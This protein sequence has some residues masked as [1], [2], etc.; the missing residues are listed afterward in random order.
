MIASTHEHL[1]IAMVN[2]SP[3]IKSLTAV[4]SNKFQS[5]FNAVSSPGYMF[6]SE[7]NHRHVFYLLEMFNYLIQY[8][9]MGRVW[10]WIHS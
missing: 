5:L 9:M 10:V 3:Y 1:L 6:Y 8:Q 4:T 7:F 2:L